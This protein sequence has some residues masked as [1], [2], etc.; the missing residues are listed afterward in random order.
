MFFRN[1]LG[2]FTGLCVLALG[3]V[4]V[5]CSGAA[6]VDLEPS[7]GTQTVSGQVYS[8]GRAISALALPNATGGDG[9]LTY[10]LNPAVSGL[11]F[12]A[13]TRTLS[14][15]PAASDMYEMTY[16]VADADGDTAS[17]SFTIAVRHPMVFWTDFDSGKIQRANLD[18]TDV[19]DVLTTDASAEPHGIA[20]DVTG[21]KIYWTEHNTRKIRR[22][23][24][25]GS[26]AEDLMTTDSSPRA[27]AIDLAG[28]K[29]YVSAGDLVRGNLDGTGAEILSEEAS[30]P[31]QIAL[32]VAGGK[33]YWVDS[34][35]DMVLRADLD[36]SNVEELV[37]TGGDGDNPYGI[38]LDIAGGKMYWNL[39][40]GSKI[41]RGNL[42]GSDEEDLL[43]RDDGLTHPQEMVLDVADGKIYWAERA[44]IR[45]ANIDGTSVEDIIDMGLSEPYGMALAIW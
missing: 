39:R 44:R 18:G 8:T 7:F 43:S 3:G 10:S 14:G 20:I 33:I 17:L 45:R 27:I 6:D 15:T 1:C 2:R 29:M 26:G 12:A 21:N 35:R 32:D 16:S 13:D 40:G 19:Q 24:L 38:A 42:D 37:V 28:G 41:Q 34:D 30:Q 9:T 31:N 36:G 25:D 23:N 5:A 4:L 11:Q 22:A